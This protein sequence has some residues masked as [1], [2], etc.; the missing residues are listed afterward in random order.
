MKLAEGV[1]L[2]RLL[3][4]VNRCSYNVLAIIRKMLAAGMIE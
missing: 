3:K 2:G 1:T 4:D